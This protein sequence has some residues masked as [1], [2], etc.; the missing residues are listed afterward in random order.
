M[1]TKH[2]IDRRW[3]AIVAEPNM[4]VRFA[5]GLGDRGYEAFVALTYEREKVGTRAVVV[6]KLR[7]SPYVWV[8]V[9]YTAGQNFVA[10]RQ[11]LGFSSAIS[12]SLSGN[13]DLNPSEV[14]ACVIQGLRQ[15]QTED[16]EVAVRRVRRKECMFREGDLVRVIAPEIFAGYEGIVRAARPGSV[17]AEIG[18]MK[19]PIRL[20]EDD[21]V[22]ARPF[23]QK[24]A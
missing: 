23:V 3:Y 21:V 5:R 20:R 13:R 4:D 9:D 24:S 16:Y 17:V 2:V 10:V 19:L 12:L 6:A 14:P 7:L 22:M 11:T 1:T 15:D 8:S 18:A